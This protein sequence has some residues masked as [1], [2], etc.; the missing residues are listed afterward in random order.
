MRKL[1]NVTNRTHQK[2]AALLKRVK[3][4]HQ[5]S[6]RRT[7]RPCQLP[8]WSPAESRFHRR[9]SSSA[10]ELAVAKAAAKDNKGQFTVLPC[11]PLAVWKWCSLIL[12]SQRHRLVQSRSSKPLFQRLETEGNFKIKRRVWKCLFTGCGRGFWQRRWNTTSRLL[13]GDVWRLPLSFFLS[14]G[15]DSL[16]E[17]RS[18]ASVA[19][20]WRKSGGGILYEGEASVGTTQVSKL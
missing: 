10:N 20:A 18:A 13:R 8:V 15:L 2:K 12:V 3:S 17:R 11:C 4:Y 6:L 14:N 19:E 5:S 16:R 9:R 1:H 7:H